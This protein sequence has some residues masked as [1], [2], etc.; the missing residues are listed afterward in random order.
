MQVKRLGSLISLATKQLDFEIDCKK[1]D[2]YTLSEIL[3]YAI[4][5]KKQIDR[6]A[7][8]G[9]IK[10]VKNIRTGKEI[11]LENNKRSVANGG[12]QWRFCRKN[13]CL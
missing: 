4:I 13:F 7:R 10:R 11:I 5:I 3:D 1:R 9:V 8:N 6:Y 12:R 2:D